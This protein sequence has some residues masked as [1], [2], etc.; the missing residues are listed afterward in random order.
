MIPNFVP[1]IGSGFDQVAAQQAGWAGFSAN[2]DAA[3]M[4]RARLAEESANDWFRN[5]ARLQQQEAQRA[6]MAA[7]TAESIAQK[8]RA[9]TLNYRL[10]AEASAESRRRFDAQ[11]KLAEEEFK[12]RKD[13][14]GKDLIKQTSFIDDMGTSLAPRF[15]AAGS[16]KDQA[17]K[18][19]AKATN[20]FVTTQSEWTRIIPYS[21]WNGKT[22]QLEKLDPISG[23][24]VA[25]S[26]TQ[27]AGGLWGSTASEFEAASAAN[28]AFAEARSKL[29]QV[30]ESHATANKTWE[31][32]NKKYA[33]TE[34]FPFQ[35]ED[36][37]WGLHSPI[38]KQSYFAKE[39]QKAKDKAAAAVVPVPGSGWPGFQGR[40]NPTMTGTA[41]PPLPAVTAPAPPVASQPAMQPMSA[42]GGSPASMFSQQSSAPPIPAL[43]PAPPTPVVPSVEFQS[44]PNKYWAAASYPQGAFYRGAKYMFQDPKVVGELSPRGLANAVFEQPPTPPGRVRVVSPQGKTGTIPREQLPTALASGFVIFPENA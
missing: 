8:N 31:E 40:Q 18:D 1:V 2:Q 16:A 42:L 39:L 19:L 27:E 36:G 11:Q 25:W 26:N 38:T 33:S 10:G 12:F 15:A 13:L 17:E 7:T 21:R 3:N 41:V 43:T 24:P 20:D 34:I 23:K 5:L 37:V 44:Q 6:D 35:R 14:T 22:G 4:N 28:K 32:L 9:D 30:Q 29:M